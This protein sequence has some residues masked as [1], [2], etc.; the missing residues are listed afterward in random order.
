LNSPAP[1]TFVAGLQTCVGIIRFRKGPE[2]LPA[3]IGL[4]AAALT[5]MVLSQ[6]ALLALPTEESH[7]NPLVVMLL[8]LALWLSGV[9]VALRAAGH[10]A[11]YVQTMTA[12]FGTQ[13]VL[14]PVLFVIR[15][16]LL[17][18]QEQPGISALAQLL[19]V[20]VV[21]W[22]LAVI[23][24][25]L[26]SATG[27]PVFACVLLALSIAMFTGLAALT[28]YGPEPDAAAPV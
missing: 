11:R 28:L 9:F 7:I 12:I 6:F 15:W 13:V 10:S 17:A 16:A 21:M 2:D 26:R 24:R 23:V 1:S 4:L 20:V 3:S 14:A 22:S 27:W 19:F 18:Y 25:I 8:D 5:G